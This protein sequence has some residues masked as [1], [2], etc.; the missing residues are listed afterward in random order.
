MSRITGGINREVKR[1]TAR[2]AC[3]AW[4][5]KAITVLATV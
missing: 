3:A 1:V 5:I 4:A 2:L